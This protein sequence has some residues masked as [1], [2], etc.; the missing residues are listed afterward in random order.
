MPPLHELIETA[1]FIQRRAADGQYP[2]NTQDTQ[3]RSESEHPSG[4]QQLEERIRQLLT[5]YNAVAKLA[6]YYRFEQIRQGKSMYDTPY[7]HGLWD[8]MGDPYL[9]G[10][11]DQPLPSRHVITTLPP[12]G[13]G[14][15]EAKAASIHYQMVLARGYT[16]DGLLVCARGA[17]HVK[18][19]E[20]ALRYHVET[21]D[22]RTNEHTLWRPLSETPDDEAPG[23]WPAVNL[24]SFGGIGIKK[25]LPLVK[26]GLESVPTEAG[27]GDLLLDDLSDAELE[28]ITSQRHRDN[29][30]I[31]TT[32]GNYWVSKGRP[33]PIE[34]IDGLVRQVDSYTATVIPLM[35]ERQSLLD[36]GRQLARRSL[37]GA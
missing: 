31:L 24:I 10:E 8:L 30:L 37:S 22:L 33:E 3:A 25:E 26:P 20:E 7:D 15:Q 36:A 17:Q 6:G 9:Y 14:S 21:L 5:G 29:G 18:P 1:D 2:E 34:A 27:T 35:Q 28:Y 32:Q 4:L 23:V 11:E 13:A 16:P 12:E 19:G